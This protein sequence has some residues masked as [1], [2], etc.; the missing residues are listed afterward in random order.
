MCHVHHVSNNKECSSPNLSFPA[1]GKQTALGGQDGAKSK[2]AKVTS[3]EKYGVSETSLATQPAPLSPIIELLNCVQPAWIPGHLPQR[4]S[5]LPKEAVG[6]HGQFTEPS[7]GLLTT[8]T[9]QAS[10]LITD[11]EKN[12]K[13]F[14]VI[15]TQLGFAGCFPASPVSL[16]LPGLQAHR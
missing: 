2:P 13:S 7:L 4:K 1:S 3:R 10:G 8:H 5:W 11:K 9:A 16:A 15:V 6:A 12:R 14:S